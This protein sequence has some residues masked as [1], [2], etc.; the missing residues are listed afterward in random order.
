VDRDVRFGAGRRAVVVAA[1]AGL[2]L[3]AFL[4]A[5]GLRRLEAFRVA[6]LR[7]PRTVATRFR[8]VGDLREL[9][10]GVARLR[11]AGLRR[12]EALR[13]A[14]LRP[15]FFLRVAF[16]FLPVFLLVVFF[17]AVFFRAVFFRPVFF[18]LAFLAVAFLR[19]AFFLLPAFLRLAFL[20][21]FLR[22]ALRLAAFFLAGFLR[23]TLRP[24]A[25][26]VLRLAGFLRDPLR[27]TAMIPPFL[28]LER[29]ASPAPPPVP[30]F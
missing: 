15:V 6:G 13:V 27:R 1:R 24:R 2:G 30:S 3:A 20:A 17:R 14:G 7:R 9:F 28:D 22:V 10:L 4:G 25:D 29:C 23:A 18:R 16:V 21:V 26:V 12:L 5:G 11:L 8:R 19:V